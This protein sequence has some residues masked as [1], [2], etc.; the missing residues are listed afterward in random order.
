MSNPFK[1]MQTTQEVS[2]ILKNKILDDIKMI[3]YSLDISDLFLMKYP[4]TV[5]DCFIR[6]EI[7]GKFKK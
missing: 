3:K 7:S 4:S 2:S 5:S 6:E 1:R